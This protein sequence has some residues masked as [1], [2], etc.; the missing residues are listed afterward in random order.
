[1]QRKQG[2][3]IN[4]ATTR[5]ALNVEKEKMKAAVKYVHNLTSLYNATVNFVINLLGQSDRIFYSKSIPSNL[6][7]MHTKKVLL[8]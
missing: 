1:M 8:I 5:V 6:F 3:E 4:L 2:K 7:K